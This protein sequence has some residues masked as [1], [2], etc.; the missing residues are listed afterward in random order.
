MRSETE[1]KKQ[2]E[3]FLKL[4][5]VKEFYNI[6]RAKIISAVNCGIVLFVCAT[7]TF[8]V[9]TALNTKTVNA[10]P[11]ETSA[12]VSLL[13]DQS[14]ETVKEN[15]IHI[16]IKRNIINMYQGLEVIN[17][18]LVKLVNKNGKMIMKT[19]LKVMACLIFFCLLSVEVFLLKNTL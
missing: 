5:G 11:V 2:G 3:S 14:E 19:V 10:Q 18:G 16:H 17:L 15:K 12:T 13:T 7:A 9:D 6:T 4:V 8:A 1:Q